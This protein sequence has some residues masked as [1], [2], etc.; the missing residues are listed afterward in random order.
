MVTVP[1]LALIGLVLME[2]YRLYTVVPRL[3]LFIDD[4]SNVY[5]RLNRPRLKVPL[6]RCPG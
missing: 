4:L 3:L 5:I 2:E 6:E 1:V